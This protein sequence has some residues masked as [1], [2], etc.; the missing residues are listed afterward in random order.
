MIE[1]YITSDNQ[2]IE[3]LSLLAGKS[4]NADILLGIAQKTANSYSFVE[5]QT[6]PRPGHPKEEKRLSPLFTFA[7]VIT[8]LRCTLEVETRV[9]DELISQTE[10]K[11]S[12]LLKLGHTALKEILH[13]A[14]MADQKSKW[15]FN[16]IHKINEDSDYSI[17]ALT[18][19]SPEITRQELL[20][21]DGVGQKA[22]DCFMLLGLEKPVF[23]VDTNV[24]RIVSRN[25]PEIFEPNTE[26][27]FTNPKQ[28]QKVKDFLEKTFTKDAID[29]QVLHTYL[30]LAEKH[31]LDL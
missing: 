5:N 13:S 10:G 27:K 7:S 22:V 28:V 1:N 21:L 26:P 17:E 31:K 30:L 2:A 3:R 4:D 18:N 15:I 12:N 11:D 23:P 29:Y 16:G 25:F 14:G 6:Y 9:T 24:F 19:N 8:S 20:K